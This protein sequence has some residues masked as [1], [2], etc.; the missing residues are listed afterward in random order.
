MPK[1]YEYLG[2]VFFFYSNEHLPLHV[3]VS[4]GD[5]ENKIELL[6]ENGKLK[7]L[8][9]FGV[10]GRKELPPQEIKKAMKFVKKYHE[11]IVEKWTMFFVMNKKVDC[12]IIK[13][14]I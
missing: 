13:Q 7:D 9:I 14:K 1:I 12:E 8:K 2:L 10:K 5:C 3:H 4:F 11:N 6:F